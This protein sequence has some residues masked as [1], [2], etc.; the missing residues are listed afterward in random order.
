LSRG[1]TILGS[2][3]KSHP[4]KFAVEQEDG[5]FIESDVSD[6]VV[7][8]FKKLGL[9]ALIMIGG[10]GTMEIAK[11]LGD[12]G[13]PIVGVPKTIDNDL[14]ATDVT[15]GFD[16]AVQ[17]IT[18]AIDKIRD[19][20][21]SHDRVLIVEVMGRDAGWLGLHSGLASGADIILIPEIPYDVEV[22]LKKIK[23]RRENNYFSSIIVISEGAKPKGGKESVLGD[24]KAGEML[25]L[26]GA[27]ARLEAELGICNKKN[28]PT[29]IRN[30]EARVSVLGYIQRGGSPSNF[31]RVLGTRLGVEAVELISRGEFGRMVSL[32]NNK[33]TS[34]SME[35]A[36]NSQKLVDPVTDELVRSGRALGICFGDQ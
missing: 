25:R 17:T 32:K 9:S 3:N 13:I 22:I 20:A 12:K 27:G 7:E 18:E 33:I 35:E 6:K 4:F 19:T 8:N 23:E 11:R 29:Y 28:T 16:T 36:T 10:D 30:L 34:V 24:R 2:S 14:N 15:F 31:D 21:L 1:G 26:H 5:S